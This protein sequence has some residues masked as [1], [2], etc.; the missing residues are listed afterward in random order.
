MEH[1]E[2]SSHG[3]SLI[4]AQVSS[5]TFHISDPVCF[6]RRTSRI[7][8]ATNPT[9]TGLSRLN[10]DVSITESDEMFICLLAVDVLQVPQNMLCI[11]YPMRFFRMAT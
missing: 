7:S 6:S 3:R 4:F 5:R 2:M 8:S 11:G 9:S 10:I 1:V